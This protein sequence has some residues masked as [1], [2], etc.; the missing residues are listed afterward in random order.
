MTCKLS[1]FRILITIY[2]HQYM[3]QIAKP[4][5]RVSEKYWDRGFTKVVYDSLSSFVCHSLDNKRPY[6]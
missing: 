4:Q 3:K 2:G 1:Q 5:D 6:K